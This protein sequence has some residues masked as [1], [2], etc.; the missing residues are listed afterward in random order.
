MGCTRRVHP[1]L[2]G[3]FMK[4]QTV[5]I[6]P[7]NDK[8][9][10]PVTWVD[11]ASP[12]YTEELKGQ[13]IEAEATI[14]NEARTVEFDDDAYSDSNAGC[15]TKTII[16]D[17][18]VDIKGCKTILSIDG[19]NIIKK[20]QPHS[21]LFIKKPAFIEG[22]AEK[23]SETDALESCTIS[24]TIEG[25]N[26]VLSDGGSYS[27]NGNTWKNYDGVDF[28]AA[29]FNRLSFFFISP[30]GN[31]I[32]TNDPS[33]GH[34]TKPV[35]FYVLLTKGHIGEVQN[36]GD[37]YFDDFSGCLSDETHT[38]AYKVSSAIYGSGSYKYSRYS[39]L[40]GSDV[41]YTF[42]NAKQTVTLQA[43][44]RHRFP[45]GTKIAMGL[46]SESSVSSAN[47]SSLATPV[48]L[49]KD[50]PFS[51]EYLSS[52]IEKYDDPYFPSTEAVSGITTTGS[53]ADVKYSLNADKPGVK[54]FEPQYFS[55]AVKINFVN[56]NKDNTMNIANSYP[57][58]GGANAYYFPLG[59][60]AATDKGYDLSEFTTYDDGLKTSVAGLITY[61]TPAWTFLG[62]IRRYARGGKMCMK[63]TIRY[64]DYM[65]DLQP[66]GSVYRDY[67]PFEIGF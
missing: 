53:L 3:E 52:R 64:L 7:N 51:P 9:D 58:D 34:P 17:K 20:K 50:F 21:Y 1:G 29:Y 66:D 57:F 43:T 56:P 54:F 24:L 6:L 13:F 59:C 5:W 2:I 16:L 27:D 14:Y 48:E 55:K 26:G 36:H 49:E 46:G 67:K 18:L 38:P 12:R 4:K 47:S 11:S 44:I 39:N 30:D 28:S 19:E 62:D 22:G 35:A 15:N 40:D 63:G 65:A 33:T 31:I 10:N 42:D 23:S 37:T 45:V 60:Y 8:A 25:T 41:S 61:N 32:C